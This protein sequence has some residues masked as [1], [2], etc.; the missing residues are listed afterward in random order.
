MQSIKLVTGAKIS[1]ASKLATLLM[2]K[3]MH[4]NW[5]KAR[6][7]TCAGAGSRQLTIPQGRQ[8]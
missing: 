1:F 6:H 2:L 8:D 4:Y 5:Q 3:K 7:P